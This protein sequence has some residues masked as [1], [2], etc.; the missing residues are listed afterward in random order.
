MSIGII[1]RNLS[2]YFNLQLQG[3]RRK[4]MATTDMFSA[5]RAIV[6]DNF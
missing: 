1:N 5:Y 3:D 6:T 2:A 4:T